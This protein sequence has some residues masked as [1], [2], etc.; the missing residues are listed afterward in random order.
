MRVWCAQ[1]TE[2][3]VL[4]EG[5]DSN[6][7]AGTHKNSGNRQTATLT[8]CKHEHRDRGGEGIRRQQAN[9]ESS[10]RENNHTITNNRGQQHNN[11]PSNRTTDE[12]TQNKQEHNQTRTLTQPTSAR[13]CKT[14]A[15]D[16]CVVCSIHR[17]TSV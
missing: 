14:N 7:T 1:F 10:N 11:N 3:R 4:D 2:T 5:T 15:N 8:T 16:A 6:H 9:G 17:D 12:T 13:H